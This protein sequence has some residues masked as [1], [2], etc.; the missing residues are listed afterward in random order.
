MLDSTILGTIFILVD[1]SIFRIDKYIF[2]LFCFF[3]N[4]TAFALNIMIDPG[5]G[6]YDAG[7]VRDGTKEADLVLKIAHLLKAQ[8]EKD[9]QFNVSLTR[10]TDTNLSL[11]SRVEM[12]EKIK[13]DLFISLHAN[14][15]NDRRA[16]GVEFF[17]Q[18][19]LPYDEESLLLSSQENQMLISNKEILNI[20]GGEDLSKKGDLT[21]IIED[22]HRQN[23]M[24]ESLHLSKSL[25]QVWQTNFPMTQA[26]I[27]QA[28]FFVVSKT[29][30]PAVLIE[31]GFL[32]NPRDLKNLLNSDFQNKIAKKIYAAIVS[33][34]EKMD[35]GTTN[36]LD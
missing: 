19:T 17:F 25:T 13:A 21:A 22:L 31:I 18:N 33:Y 34:K 8:L 16:K 11:P 14:S 7:A 24:N 32:T 6:G 36:S 2:I 9:S 15:A 30:M 23:R 10:T 26:V 1:V 4:T 29:T 3:G 27:K 28:P 20:S 35:N 12:A 5:H